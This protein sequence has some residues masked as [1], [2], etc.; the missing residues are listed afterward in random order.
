M[1][2]NISQLSLKNKTCIDVKTMND[3][4]TTPIKEEDYQSYSSFKATQQNVN[5]QKQTDR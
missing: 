3:L 5:I 1:R 2:R 4:R